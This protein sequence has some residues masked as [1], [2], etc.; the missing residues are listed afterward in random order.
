MS[1][2]LHD[3]WDAAAETPYHPPVSKGSQPLVGILLL[4]FGLSKHV[5]ALER[6]IIDYEY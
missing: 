6:S 2:P 4:I 1:T 5:H 3:I